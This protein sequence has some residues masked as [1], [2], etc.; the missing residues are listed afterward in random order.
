MTHNLYLNWKL[1]Y[2]KTSIGLDFTIFFLLSSKNEFIF[3]YIKI[4]KCILH[5]HAEEV[6]RIKMLNSNNKRK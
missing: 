4:D 3:T 5:I 1:E 2:Q 6:E